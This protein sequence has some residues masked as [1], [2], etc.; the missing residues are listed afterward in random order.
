MKRRELIACVA[1]ANGK[2]A[3]AGSNERAGEREVGRRR[4]AAEFRESAREI[5]RRVSREDTEGRG[6]VS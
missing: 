6:K 2:H 4:I 3:R 5:G 1:E